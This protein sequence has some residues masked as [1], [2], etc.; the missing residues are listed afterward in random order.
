LY[1]STQGGLL[2]RPPGSAVH[3]GQLLAVNVNA[4]SSGDSDD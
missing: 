1:M 4:V 3:G 2:A